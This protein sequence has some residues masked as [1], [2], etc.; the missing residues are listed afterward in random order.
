MLLKKENAERTVY[1]F[2]HKILF[3]LLPIAET[4]Y[5]SSMLSYRTLIQF[6]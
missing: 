6:Q 4:K 5:I 3:F 2:I 1:S